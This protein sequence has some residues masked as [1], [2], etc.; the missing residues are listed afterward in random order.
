[1]LENTPEFIGRALGGVRAGADH[2]LC[3]GIDLSGAAHIEVSSPA[4]GDGGLMPAV[5]TAD[6]SGA[7]PP[8]FWRGVPENAAAVLVVIE[9]ADSPT[10]RPIVHLLALAPAKGA[11]LAEEGALGPGAG[12]FLLGRNSF[13]GE[14][15]LP[16]DPPPGHGPHAYVAQVYAL[17]RT[18]EFSEG[19]SKHDAE[20]ALSEGVLGFGVTHAVYGRGGQGATAQGERPAFIGGGALEGA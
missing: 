19:F 5:H 20:K 13:G 17:A 8:L 16:P 14:G 4:F 3:A 18:P 6:G 2:L 7:S 10:P 12:L 1:M 11:T 9:D 15:W